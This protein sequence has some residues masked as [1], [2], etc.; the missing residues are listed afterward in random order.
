MKGTVGLLLYRRRRGN[1]VETSRETQDSRHP[2]GWIEIWISAGVE[3]EADEKTKPSAERNVRSIAPPDGSGSVVK[4]STLTLGT[5]CARTG[6]AGAKTSDAVVTRRAM[7]E[8]RIRG[9][10]TRTVID[11][12]DSVATS[13]SDDP[14]AV[15]NRRT[16]EVQRVPALGLRPARLADFTRRETRLGQNS[17]WRDIRRRAAS[18]KQEDSRFPP[19]RSALVLRRLRFP[20]L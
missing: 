14:A 12:F 15:S 6:K 20:P 2:A 5:P 8:R 13:E 7:L 19:A 9:N 10:N 11:T 18:R 1:Q 3:Y 16:K 4:C 17:A